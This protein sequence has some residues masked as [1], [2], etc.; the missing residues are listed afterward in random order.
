MQNL[1]QIEQTSLKHEVNG[2]PSFGGFAQELVKS[3]HLRLTSKVPPTG[4]ES[5][6]AAALPGR[7]ER[8]GQALLP[9]AGF[10]AGSRGDVQTP[11][12]RLKIGRRMQSCPTLGFSLRGTGGI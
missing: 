3:E 1:Y 7:G 12:G 4:L 6:G 8:V 9:A 5:T 2:F 10:L 11:A